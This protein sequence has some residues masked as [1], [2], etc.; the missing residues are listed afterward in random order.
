MPTP[1]PPSGPDLHEAAQVLEN[2][3]PWIPEMMIVLGSGLGGL[4]SALQESLEVPFSKIPGLPEAGV[5]GHQGSFRAGLLKG[6]RVLLQAGRFHLYEGHP[7]GVVATPV[8][9]AS[10]LGIERL[11]LT[12][13]AGGINRRFRPGSIMLID[14]HLNFMWS[15]PLS[16]PVQDG[17]ERFPDMSTPYDPAYQRLALEVAVE[18]EMELERGIYAGVLGPNYETPTE[19]RMLET[20]GADAVG[21]STVPEVIV[22]RAQGMRVLAFSLITNHAAGISPT[23]LSH[24]DVLA[25]GRE[26]GPRLESLIRKVVERLD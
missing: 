25:A 6:R 10:Q 7:P 26:A 8:R 13:A 14:D 18:Q 15:S 1:K 19:I 4:G 22:A 11:I 5:A 9:V 23:P 17:E 16:G 20:L 12:N 2:K 24:E 3:L 21:M